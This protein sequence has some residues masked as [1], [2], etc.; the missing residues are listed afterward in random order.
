MVERG[1]LAGRYPYVAGMVIFFLVPYLGVSSAL[2]PIE[3][4]IARQ[5]HTSLQSVSL[6]SGMANAGY[7]VGTVVAVLLAQFF[8]QR[9]VLLLYAGVLVLGSVLAASAPDIG[10]FAAGHVAQGF[11]TS[12]L[13]IAA[14][15]PLI[16]DYPVQ[17]L[18]VTAV[19]MNMCI[20]G[21]VA[22]GPVV[23]GAQA[24]FHA[25]RPLFWIVAGIALIGCTFSALTYRYV[26]PA[27]PNAPL[28]LT[29]VALAA[30]GC[31]AAFFGASEMLTHSFLAPIAAGPLFGGLALLITLFVY[32][33]RGTHV[34]LNIKS[35]ASTVPVAGIV[36]AICAAV[37]SVSAVALSVALLSSRYGPM[38]VGLLF[39]PEFVGAVAAAAVF[40]LVFSTRFLHFFAFGGMLVLGAGVALIGGAI[41]PTQALTIVGSAL[42]GIGVGTSVVPA[43]F[44]AGFSLLSRS[45]QRV[46]A[47]VELMRAIAAFMVAPIFLHFAV[48]LTDRPTAATSTVYWICF[49]LSVGG[50][51]VAT[52][53]YVLGGFR[54]VAV[55]LVHWFAG[56]GPA[57]ESPPLLGALRGSAHG[58]DLPLPAESLASADAASGDAGVREP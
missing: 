29:A 38:H 50:A 22:L 49:G 52:T 18:R 37:A 28:D 2:A 32:E 23:G 10:V 48:T 13:L 12:L 21:A 51:A 9:N 8:P 45:V 56:E 25:W 5:L 26:P 46:F 41:P 11:C 35:L 44:L 3:P 19:I 31:A 16:L 55:A 34:L 4:T 58:P 57:W 15:P 20:F 39:L 24:S 33:Y 36:V 30:S 6:A 53:I 1:P 47:M 17:K 42:I 27:N 40:G 7:A 14:V 54:P 43:L